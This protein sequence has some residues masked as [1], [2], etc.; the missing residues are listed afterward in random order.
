MFHQIK[1]ELGEE[2]IKRIVESQKERGVLE[3]VKISQK[4]R[5]ITL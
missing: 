1:S 5:D 4:K 3:M 2:E